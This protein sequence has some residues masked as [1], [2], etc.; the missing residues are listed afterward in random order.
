M[1]RHGWSWQVPARRA[2]ERDDAAGDGM[3]ERHV[4]AG[5]T[6]AAAHKAWLVVEDESGFSTTPPTTR[7]WSPRGLTR[8]SECTDEPGTRTRSPH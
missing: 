4:A 7:T 6:T 3:S 8:S 2:V 1:H 5:K